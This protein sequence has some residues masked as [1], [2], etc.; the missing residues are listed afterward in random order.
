MTSCQFVVDE[1]NEK[2]LVI[3]NT[4]RPL[5]NAR[6]LSTK[7]MLRIVRRPVTRAKLWGWQKLTISY[8]SNQNSPY[9][10]ISF[11]FYFKSEQLRC[12]VS[13]GPLPVCATTCSFFGYKYAPSQFEKSTET[14]WNLLN[15]AKNCEERHFFFNTWVGTVLK[16]HQ[17]F[18][19]DAFIKKPRSFQYCITVPK[20]LSVNLL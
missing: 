20:D 13:I 1:I 6:P 17:Q 14:R 19:S 11:N 3:K 18:L 8:S 10:R 2:L 15:S 16:Y 7:Q 4:M 5:K 12:K 9:W